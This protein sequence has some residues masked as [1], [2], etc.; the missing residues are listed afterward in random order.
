MKFNI[1]KKQTISIAVVLVLGAL[2]A[3]LILSMNKAQPEGDEHGDASHA[4]AAGHGEKEHHD[5]EA[6]NGHELAKGHSDQE[7]QD[8]AARPQ[9]GP[10]GGK[11]FAKDGYGVEVTIFEQGV[12]PEFRLYTYRDGKPLDAAASKI[13]LTLDRLGRTSQEFAFTKEKDYLKGNAV[14]EEPHS[15]NVKIAAQH[16]G[17]P[18]LFAYE[19][20]EARVTM[21]NQQLKQNGVEVQTAGPARITSAL[22]L[23]GEI[24][25]NEDRT[26]HIVPRLTGM[27]ESVRASAGDRVRKGQ[28]LAVISS[29]ALADQRSELLAAQKRLGLA[30]TTFEREKKL[31]QEKISAEQDYLQARNAMQEAEISLQGAQQKLASLGAGSSNGGNLTRYEIRSPID[32]TV[33]E[34]RIAIGESLKDDANIFVVADLSTVWA[35]MTV[36]AKDL[37]AVKVG[38]KATVKAT[39]FEFKSS[40]TLSYVGALV[41]EQTR[42]AKARVVLPNPKGIWRP[43]LPV[44]IDLV[45]GEIEVPVAV[46]VEA[47]QTVNEQATVFGRYGDSFEARPLELGRSD[48]KFTEVVKGLYAGEQYAAKNSFLIKADLGKSGAS[49][50]H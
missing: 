1:N 36:Y 29:Q 34:K 40:G 49:H 14:V 38:Q 25:L 10:H 39:A 42:T 33:T 15:F 23:I 37:N 45:A 17:K 35:E 43:G 12:G 2:L 50:D 44:N 8:E 19:Q 7:H 16:A 30:R 22:Q 4:E 6:K 41:G 31:W 3:M 46:S 47:V 20:I 32:G 26:V 24:R 5:D 9:K 27:V 48:G 11:L 21:T 18:Y 13:T 28:L